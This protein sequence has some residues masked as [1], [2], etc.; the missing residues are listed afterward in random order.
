MRHQNLCRITDIIFCQSLLF[1]SFNTLKKAH[2]TTYI[3]KKI[4]SSL[5]RHIYAY[6]GIEVSLNRFTSKA[7]VLVSFEAKILSLKKKF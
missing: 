7:I 4:F 3:L 1:N 5:P 6:I 2:E